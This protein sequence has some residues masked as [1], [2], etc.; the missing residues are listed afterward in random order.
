MVKM[1]K[2]HLAYILRIEAIVVAVNSRY[3]G[4]T[5]EGLGKAC[6]AI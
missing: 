3:L 1:K 5:W 2:R 6:D 4:T